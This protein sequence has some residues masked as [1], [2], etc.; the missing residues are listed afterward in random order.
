MVTVE[1]LHV[2]L[3]ILFK[4]GQILKDCL[5]SQRDTII[6]II[7][8]I[9]T[10]QISTSENGVEACWSFWLYDIQDLY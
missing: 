9:I 10:C 3:I 1:E 2:E 7:I 6:I 4:K 5:F 8:I